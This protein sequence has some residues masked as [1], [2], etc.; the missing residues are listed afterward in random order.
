MNG[1]KMK[2]EQIKNIWSAI[3]LL[4]FHLQLLQLCNLNYL[5]NNA[6]SYVSQNTVKTRMNLVLLLFLDRL[7]PTKKL[8][9]HKIEKNCKLFI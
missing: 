6:Q 8:I 5:L 3:S 4:Y 2:K 9:K 1:Y 7:L